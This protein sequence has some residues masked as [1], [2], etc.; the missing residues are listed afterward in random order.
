MFDQLQKRCRTCRQQTC[1]CHVLNTDTL[2]NID[3][4]ILPLSEAVRG[5]RKALCC[6]VPTCR[7]SGLAS[8]GFQKVSKEMDEFLV[9]S[10]KVCGA[11]R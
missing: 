2:D 4:L 10:Y 1:L 11:S 6:E 7:I 9:L 5:T 3:S 8:K